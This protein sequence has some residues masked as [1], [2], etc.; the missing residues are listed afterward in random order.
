MDGE[1][2]KLRDDAPPPGGNRARRL[3]LVGVVGLL[4]VCG[5]A[6]VLLGRAKPSQNPAP[7]LDLNKPRGLKL[8]ERKIT[9]AV[10]TIQTVD[11]RLPCSGLLTVNLSFPKG[12]V[13]S[14][15]LVSQEEREKMLARQTFAHVEGF[16]ARTSTGSYQQSAQLPPGRYCL[17]LLDENASRSVVEVNAHLGDLK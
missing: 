1:L 10:G 5:G 17:V 11:I 16:D 2:W 9:F 3:V 14:T 8:V 6:F 7:A 4:L 15:F 13:L 12:V